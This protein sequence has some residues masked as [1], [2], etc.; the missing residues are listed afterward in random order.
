MITPN[1]KPPKVLLAEM[2]YTGWGYD[3]TMGRMWEGLMAQFSDL[4]PSPIVWKL[5]PIH[6]AAH[7]E[8]GEGGWTVYLSPL[9]YTRYPI[10]LGYRYGLPMGLPPLH[11]LV[12]ILQEEGQAIAVP[13]ENAFLALAR[14]AQHPAHALLAYYASAPGEPLPLLVEMA[15]GSPAT[16]AS[17]HRALLQV[18]PDLPDLTAHHVFGPLFAHALES[19]GEVEPIPL[20]ANRSL[21][22]G[23]PVQDYRPLF[24]PPHHATV[25]EGSVWDSLYK[26]LG[27]DPFEWKD[28]WYL[29]VKGGEEE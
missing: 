18:D 17:W 11:A 24:G 25:E 1:L 3:P 28:Y 15:V 19:A 14:S 22:E 16:F 9:L 29:K 7:R 13:L 6:K 12:H 20:G 27:A 8:R 4:I 26:E 5:G 2:A 10:F 23:P 21:K